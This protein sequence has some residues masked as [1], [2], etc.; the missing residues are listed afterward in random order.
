MIQNGE[1]MKRR[2]HTGAG[3]GLHV[4]QLDGQSAPVLSPVTLGS[5]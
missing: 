4:D 3:A 1:I 2:E 5:R